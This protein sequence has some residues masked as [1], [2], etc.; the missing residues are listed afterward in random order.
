MAAKVRTGRDRAMSHDWGGNIGLNEH[1]VSQGGVG[2]F[3]LLRSQGVQDRS[4]NSQR[5]HRR[6]SIRDGGW[7][8]SRINTPSGVS[9]LVALG[10]DASEERASGS[11]VG[12]AVSARRS[13]ASCR[14]SRRGSALRA[15]SSSPSRDFGMDEAAP[16]TIGARSG[17]PEGLGEC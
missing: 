5:A 9:I 1:A 4:I 12:I 17:D 7:R 3:V 8:G 13:I 11:V 14:L 2:G 16:F 10:G 6:S 15:W